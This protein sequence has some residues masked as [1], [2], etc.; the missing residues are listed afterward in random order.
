[1]H[2]R[3]MNQDHAIRRCENPMGLP[4]HWEGER[5]DCPACCEVYP[6]LEH[7]DRVEDVLRIERAIEAA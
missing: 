5:C 2:D 4:S 6:S 3:F 7:K 1:M